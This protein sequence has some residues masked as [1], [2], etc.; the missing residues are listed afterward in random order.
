MGVVGGDVGGGDG[1]ANELRGGGVLLGDQAFEDFEVGDVEGGEFGFG[2]EFLVEV[3]SEG[4]GDV[5]VDTLV[6][7]LDQW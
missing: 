6:W 1:Y 2:F 3:G 7:T 5:R 4:E